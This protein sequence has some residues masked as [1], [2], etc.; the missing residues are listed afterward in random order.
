MAVAENDL[1]ISSFTNTGTFTV[2]APTAA[3]SGKPII[4]CILTN[5]RAQS[6]AITPASG[7]T[8]VAEEGLTSSTNVAYISVW[9]KTS[10]GSE[11]GNYTFTS[12]DGSTWGDIAAFWLS[13]ADDSNPVDQTAGDNNGTGSG[14]TATAPTVTTTRDGALVQRIWM[15]R[16]GLTTMTL[17]ALDRT[18]WN[19]SRRGAS[20]VDDQ[21]SA[22]ATGTSA[23]T[24]TATNRWA[25]MTVAY[26]AAL[27]SGTQAL[28]RFILNIT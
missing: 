2:A 25:A 14:T 22:G 12:S 1:Q 18:L 24:L 6:S 28:R 10:S 13:G 21:T 7:F 23:A 19:A 16:N 9:K 20:G 8:L 4:V 3:P 11:S 26:K 17:P 5:D 15:D 27:P